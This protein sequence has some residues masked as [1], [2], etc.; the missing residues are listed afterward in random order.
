MARNYVRENVPLSRFGVLVA[1][2]ESIVAS[3]SQQ[4][5]DPLLCFD[6]LSDLI[7]SIDEEPKESILLW[8][9]KCEDAL[10]SLLILGARRPVRHLASVAMARIIYKGDSISIYSRVSSLQGFLSD[11]K[12]SEPQKVAG[13]AQCLGELYLHFGRRVTSGLLE[14]TII[15]TKLMKFHEEFVRQEAL[16]LLQNALEGS[17]GSAASSAYSEAFRLI[18]RFAIG[19][20]SF[21]VRIAAAR[22]LKAFAHIGGPGLGV[23][24]LD[25]LSSHCVKAGFFALEDPISSVRDAF[26]EALGLLLALGMNPQAQVQPRGKGPSPPARKLEG[27]LQRHLS[28]PFTKVNGY[29]SKDV[30][31]GL[32]LSWVYFL[33]ATCLRYMHPDSELQ[34][35]ALQVIEMLRFDNPVDAHAL[36]CVLYILRVG[37]TDQM[38]EPTQRS[39]LVFLGKQFQSPDVSA[40]MK[41][42]SLRILSYTLKTLGEVP[43][44]FKEVF[45][46]TMVAAVSHS[47]QLVRVEAALTLR[48]LAEIDPTC[49]GGLISYG[50]TILNALRDNVSFE[51]GS[52]LKVELDLLHGQATVLAALVSI[53]PR[54]PLGYP[55]R[56]PKLV[57]EVAKKMLTDSSK[58]AMVATVEKEA[59]WLL[60]SSLLA[61]M[62]KEELEDQVFDILS[63]WATLFSGNAEHV[64]K[65]NGDLASGVCVLSAAVDALTSFV[66]CF[67][68]PSAG[69][70]GVLLQPVMVY[71]SRALSY[72]SLVAAKEIPN[73]K[74]AINIFFIRTLTAYQSL[75]DPMAYK[76]DHPQLIQLC[77][78]PYRDASG[79]EES[80]C[81]RLLLDKRDAWVGPWIPGR[82]WF[83]DELRAFQGGKDGL[84]PCV[85]ENDVFSFPQPETINKTL[86][87]QM[88][89]CF[90]IMF[91]S[92]D[93]SGMLS[94]LGMIEQCLKS[95]KKQSWHAASV[96]NI[97]VGLLAGLKALV[98]VRPQPLGPEIIQ[99]AQAIFQSI[100]A[101][102]DICASQ[103]RAS[104]EGLGL[105]ARL[106]NDI[107]TARMTRG[108]LGDLTGV[109]DSNYAGSIA[110]ALGC[111][112][113]SAG[114]MALSSLV[115]S[116]V[117]SISLL[118]KTS[119]PGLQIWSLHGLLLT[120]EAAGLSFVSHVQATLALAMDI[121]L[122]EENGR[123]D[124]QQGV[125]RL[126]NAIVAVLGPELAPGSIFFSRCKSVVAEI[127]S[128]Q[129]TATLLECVRFTQQLVLFA[130]QAVS[131]HSHVQT[132]LSTL[133][134][135]Q[136]TLRHL[137][138]TTLRHLIEKDP[139]SVIE[140]RIEDNLFHMLNEETDSEIGNLVRSTIMR[141]LYASCPSC[142]SHWMLICRNMVL[143]TSSRGNAESNNSD[144]DPLNGAESD[145][146]FGDDGENMVSSSKVM[147][148]QGYAFE[149]SSV[150]PNRDKH[151][152]YRT[153]V[154]AAECLSHLPTAVGSNPAHFE[155]SLARKRP[156][157]GQALCDWLV[158]HIQELISLAYQ[159]STIQFE[160]MRPLGVGL[161][162]TIIDKFEMVSDPELPGHLLLEQFQAQL[163]SAVRTALDASSGPI[164]L[165]AGLQLATKIMT[166]GIISGDQAAVKRIFSLIS[167]PLNDFKDLYYPSFAEWVS[168]K[169]KVRLLA[170][171]ASLKCY[172]Y[173]FLRRH[174]DGI[175]DE[176]VA[177]L[178][179]FSKSSSIL[180]RYWIQV[181]KDYSYIFLGLNLN[182]NWNPF[183]DGIQS[184]LV[185]S[186][187]LACLEEAWP[188]ILQ[189]AALDAVPMNS[190]G[191]GYSRIAAENN[192]KSSLISGY[193]MVEL[194]REE[195]QFLWGFSMLILFQGL[196][197]TPGK[198]MIT[199]GSAKVKF[200]VD[201][202]IKV[203]NPIGLKLY[204]IVLPVF[205]FLSTQNFFAA[206]F[207]SLNICLELLQ[208]F[209]YSMCLDNSW[210]SLAISVLSQVVQNCPEDFFETEN[211][212]YLGTELCLAYLFKLFQSTDLNLPDHPDK[213]DLLSPLFITAKKLMEYFKPKKQ[214]MSVT[215][216]FLLIGFKCLRQA[217]TEFFLSKVIDFV[218]F[219]IALLKKLVKDV[220]TLGD[221]D[222]IYLRSIFGICLNA[223]ADLTND[224]I[225][226]IHQLENNRSNTSKLIQLKLAFSVEQNVS[227][228]KLAF[229]I[230]FPGDC[231]ESNPIGFGVFK[232]CT[233]NIHSVLTDSNV[234]VQAVGL[235]V[236]KS[237]T[238]RYTNK[239]DN[240]LTIFFIGVLVGDLFTI[241][242]KILQKPI[243]K[244]SVAIVGECLR[245]MML[246]QT[247]L[248][249]SECQK[250]FMN[251]LLEAI[252]MVFSASEDGSSKEAND[253]RSTAVRLVSHL[254]EIPSS[255]VHLKEVLLSMPAVHRQQFQGMIRASVNQDLSTP[256][257]KPMAPLLEIKLP[258]P[259]GGKTER[260]SMPSATSIHLTESSKETDLPL[261]TVPITSND[262]S[263]EESE[264]DEDDWD[265]FQSFPASTNEAGTDSKEQ[266][267]AEEPGLAENPSA[268]E[269]SDEK[270]DSQEFTSSKPLGSVEEGNNA[271]HLES[272]G[273]HDL[274]SDRS[275]DRNEAKV[276]QGFQTNIGATKPSDETY[277]EMEQKLVPNL[278]SE[279]RAAANHDNEKA[280][281]VQQHNENIEGLVQKNSEG[282]EQVESL[283]NKI[284]ALST[285][286][287]QVK[288]EERSD[289]VNIVEKH[290]VEEDRQTDEEQH[291]IATE[292][293]VTETATENKKNEPRQ[294][295]SDN[296][297]LPKA[298]VFLN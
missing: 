14:T 35:Y 92:Q 115:P 246:L 270:D 46:N 234:Q 124:L 37:V 26:A 241:T 245:I 170:A 87:N 32:T 22:C 244:E 240:S 19:D 51:K 56:L 2:L 142:P 54:L 114:G 108:L 122:S 70:N 157:N 284:E 247:V 186:K 290:E 285:D 264:E 120:I 297:E 274:I 80:S 242:Q 58:N 110:L 123:V 156:A 181:L 88:L 214:F 44:E 286:D 273:E 276:V 77:T 74:P 15:A 277:E 76:S 208:I 252:V 40:A 209:T 263:M 222:I 132:L 280:P 34:D 38:T 113:R 66:R 103:R 28:L 11:G 24:E 189:A 148:V 33:Q 183:L 117:N 17:G 72:I 27:G 133:S 231:K 232:I 193:S 12:R 69:N 164:L 140:E 5:P 216:A 225:M 60:L 268:L 204:E 71:L 68:S 278:E 161:L 3:S 215:L 59:G 233:E 211:F 8:Q 52:N 160:S 95:G 65:Q 97:C 121:L 127:S 250:G 162:C 25:N 48:A 253:I 135:R 150:K 146:N 29:R 85:W 295:N 43:S 129:E 224:F 275:S 101:E 229:E 254:A 36:A 155:L 163:V 205:Q 141:L 7:S 235:Q 292:N 16:L 149:A 137:A 63:L 31:I 136:P 82:D 106:G 200:G 84:M 154:F 221:D 168:C 294:G 18:T 251:L 194:D 298:K 111:I 258:G 296:L 105:L 226:G 203:M 153:K 174:H 131:V 75:P 130:P 49:V 223:I 23:G 206:E 191:K 21:V 42:A 176:F 187:L 201:S 218:K 62:P 90:G 171:H 126:I 73:I 217:S 239:E 207:L 175:P 271:E 96:T 281:D 89:L 6:L 1:Q 272:S 248:K 192:S 230:E 190:D 55:A 169:I 236:L 138:V 243:T 197:V 267:V 128:W 212:A 57:L 177:L 99:L 100:L 210:N 185:S 109:T 199:L 287:E 116:T 202:P 98:T 219:G 118:A 184:P 293:T 227:L 125:G 238:Q 291:N 9:R 178:P 41:I 259:V 269:G 180:G 83:E 262:D 249:S 282:D 143:S 172:T 152:R 195:Y 289:E 261:T 257:M 144:S 94:L 288:G 50:V 220:V 45:D 91:A 13:A 179:L 173:A 166:S 10:Y 53:S 102:G 265:A 188:V 67:I 198:Q 158:I 79:C 81:L 256:Q 134:S 93:S 86:M 266:S 39:F 167:R 61:S 4:S 139:V 283:E 165:E 78:I 112:H 255:A 47:S 20:K 30:R 104:S 145:T 237:M 147:S 151:L 279:D 64:I 107:S 228:A 159:I 213:E 119:I 182:R 260:D 196:Q